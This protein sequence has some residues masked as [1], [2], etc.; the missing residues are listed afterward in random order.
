MTNKETVYAI[1]WDIIVIGGIFSVMYYKSEER[2][3]SDRMTSSQILSINGLEINSAN[4]FT[5]LKIIESNS[6]DSIEV[7][8]GKDYRL[9]GEREIHKGMGNISFSQELLEIYYPELKTKP[10]WF[11]ARLKEKLFSNG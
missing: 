2:L 9:V 7:L 10:K 8:S 3:K 6:I 4:I 11:F 1:G 5:I